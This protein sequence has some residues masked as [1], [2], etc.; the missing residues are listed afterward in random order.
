MKCRATSVA[1]NMIFKYENLFVCTISSL[2]QFLTSRFVAVEPL[3]WT[4]LQ[5]FY[6]I[7]IMMMMMTMP[8]MIVFPDQDHVD[9]EDDDDG[10]MVLMVIMMKLPIMVLVMVMM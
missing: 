9:E 2:S 8:I 6:L 3:W 1:K 4:K 5:A 7:M 10:D